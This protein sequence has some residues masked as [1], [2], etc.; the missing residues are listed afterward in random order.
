MSSLIPMDTCR[1]DKLD[2][3]INELRNP[4]GPEVQNVALDPVLPEKV[5]VVVVGGGIV[6]L[7]TA[8]HL[9]EKGLSVAV[10]EKGRIAGEQSSRN[11]GWVRVMRRDLRELRLSIE[12]SKMW[13]HF[14]QL[15]GAN[16]G[17][18]QCGL[19]YMT[20]DEKTLDTYVT[21]LRRAKDLVGESLH[22]ELVGTE[23]IAR[24]LPHSAV[25]FKGGLY[26]PTDGRAEPQQAAP[27][28]A[29][30]L[31]ARGVSV[32]AP[33]AVRGVETSAGAASS[34]VTEWGE[35]KCKGVVI[36]GGAWSRL[37]CR[38]LGVELPQLLAKG[39]VLRTTAVKD[40]PT[41]GASNKHFAFRKRAD[42][43]YTIASGFRTYA[44]LTPDAFRLFFKYIQALKSQ[45]SALRLSVG[46]RFFSELMR[47]SHWP[48]DKKSPFEDVREL[49]PSPVLQSTEY[50]LR[51]FLEAFPQLRGIRVAQRWAGYM[52]VTPDAI[53]VISGVASLPGLYVST[54]Y[55]G[56]GFGIAPA[57]GRLMADIICN[58]SPIVDAR[59]FRLERFSDGS[60]TIVDAGF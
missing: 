44:D 29:A 53:P 1:W 10:C 15:L 2:R 54:G 36:A 45:G 22:T 31:R 18:Q 59:D 57:A 23:Q 21:W 46:S 49:D 24:L 27:A 50:A 26:T 56:H 52:D 43:G 39:S 58:D 33:C 5:D 13:G 42:G 32:V 47:P 48:L 20:S 7:C 38:S 19:L 12:S 30:A 34:V 11:W 60:P 51:G 37:L 40:G 35:I 4:M 3:Q 25:R 8:L 14:D 16:T 9:S 55:S 17:Y 41:I 6:G 28:I